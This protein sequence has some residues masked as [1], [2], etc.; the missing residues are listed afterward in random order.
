MW[1]DNPFAIP[2]VPWVNEVQREAAHL[3]EEYLRSGEVQAQFMESGFRPGIYVEQSELLT[4]PQ[5]LNFKQPEVILGQVPAGT[6]RVIRQSWQSDVGLID[7]TLGL[8]IPTSAGTAGP[9]GK[10]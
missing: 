9:S 8:P 3:V 7:T 2:D 6:A 1:H 4:P 10:Q 5:G